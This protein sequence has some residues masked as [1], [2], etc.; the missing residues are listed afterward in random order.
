M[1]PSGNGNWDDAPIDAQLAAPPAS[2]EQYPRDHQSPLG[3]PTPTLFEDMF[4]SKGA[5]LFVLF[6]VTGALGIPLLWKNE[7]FSDQERVLW[8]IVVT[9]YT[10]ML[11]A[12]VGWVCLWSYRRIYGY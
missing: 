9:I 12:G 7:K 2:Y 5:V 3:D 8:S 6:L 10:I 11:I 1:K 4:Q